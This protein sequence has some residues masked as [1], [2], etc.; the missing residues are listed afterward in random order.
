MKRF[1]DK[2]D[3]HFDR[4]TRLT[5]NVSKSYNDLMSSFKALSALTAEMEK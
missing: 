1:V 2:M 4:F 5:E 3:S